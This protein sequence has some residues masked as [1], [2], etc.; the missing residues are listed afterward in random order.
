MK[1][2]L[3]H[4]GSALL[5]GLA[6]LAFMVAASP[7]MADWSVEADIAAQEVRFDATVGRSQIGRQPGSAMEE[8]RYAAS[9]AGQPAP[10]AIP[11]PVANEGDP[12]SF[13]EIDTSASLAGMALGGS[14]RA[15][16]DPGQIKRDLARLKEQFPE[17]GYFG[18][19]DKRRA[20]H[21]EIYHGPGSLEDYVGFHVLEDKIDRWTERRRYARTEFSTRPDVVMWTRVADDG[22]A[23]RSKVTDTGSEGSI[24]HIE[25]FKGRPL[26]QPGAEVTIE[27]PGL[28]F[29]FTVG[30][31]ARIQ[32]GELEQCGNPR[33]GTSDDEKECWARARDRVSRRGPPAR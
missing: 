32:C 31:N 7:V 9:A 6:A 4:R 24:S 15:R 19:S 11:T 25:D 20:C 13:A 3:T 18:V 23:F 10:A 2:H 17:G 5:R 26:G 16:P 22:S 8:L 30:V 33:D 29:G 1:E 21:V 27:T 14:R 28:L 12:R